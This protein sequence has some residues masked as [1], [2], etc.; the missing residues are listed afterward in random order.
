MH[1]YGSSSLVKGAGK[2]AILCQRRLEG[3]G[4]RPL[5]RRIL[6]VGIRLRVP[7]SVGSIPPG[8]SPA[9]GPSGSYTASAGLCAT[10]LSMVCSGLCIRDLEPGMLVRLLAGRWAGEYG[11][12]CDPVESVEPGMARVRFVK[13]LANE[14][15]INTGETDKQIKWWAPNWLALVEPCPRCEIDFRMDDDYLCERC[16]YG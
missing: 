11:R 13:T 4:I 10:I 1:T 12:V 16:R 9:Q 3:C 5:H 14:V 7:Q 6:V 15:H 2:A 8:I